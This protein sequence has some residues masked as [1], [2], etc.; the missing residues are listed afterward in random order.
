MRTVWKLSVWCLPIATKCRNW[1]AGFSS[2]TDAKPLDAKQER[3]DVQSYT[4]LAGL[5]EEEG[6]FALKLQLEEQ[7][8][9]EDRHGQKMIRLL[10]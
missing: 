10:G 4:R 9:D 3:K 1:C 2:R 6:Q 5:A 7:A 8:A